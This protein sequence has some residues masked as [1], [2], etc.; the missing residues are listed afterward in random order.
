MDQEELSDGNSHS[1]PHLCIGMNR[2][3]SGFNRNGWK[4][5][6]YDSE[7]DLKELE[8]EKAGFEKIYVKNY[9]GR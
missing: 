8:Q 1:N 6:D 9:L 7:Q 3:Q 5:D 4:S 2:E